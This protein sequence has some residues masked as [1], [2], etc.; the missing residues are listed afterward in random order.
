MAEAPSVAGK[1]VMPLSFII[2]FAWSFEASMPMLSAIA[3]TAVVEAPTN[4][5]PTPSFLTM[6][7]KA[8]PTPV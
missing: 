8:C 3:L 1:P 2:S 4:K 5:P 7:V 6:S